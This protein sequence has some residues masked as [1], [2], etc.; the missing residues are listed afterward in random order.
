MDCDWTLYPYPKPQ[1]T[2]K[3]KMGAG[4]HLSIAKEKMGDGVH[5]S[6]ECITKESDHLSYKFRGEVSILLEVPNKFL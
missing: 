2:I 3:E 6:I 4:V 5:L 1:S